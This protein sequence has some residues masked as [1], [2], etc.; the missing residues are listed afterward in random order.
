MRK[1]LDLRKEEKVLLSVIMSDG[2]KL[3]VYTPSK[4]ISDLFPIIAEKI[5]NIS[6]DTGDIQERI[7]SIEFLYE[8]T[9]LILSRNKNEITYSAE[10]IKRLMTDNQMLVFMTN[11]SK[12]IKEIIESKN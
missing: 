9:A 7:E 8:A 6:K 3:D 4:Y 5:R 10:Q 1:I 2:E 12:A 11:Y